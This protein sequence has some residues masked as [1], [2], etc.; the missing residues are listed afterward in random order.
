MLGHPKGIM[1]KILVVDDELDIREF[2]RSFFQKRGIDVLSAA[3]GQEALRLIEQDVFDLVL[4][5]VRMEGMSGIDVLRELRRRN[6]AVNVVMVS[7]ADDVASVKEAVSL[8]CKSFIR[9]P[10][11]LEEFKRVVLS[12]IVS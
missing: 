12:H 8:G 2:S 10:L 9:K 5:D 1:P 7:G 11:V 4:L 3:D 6:I